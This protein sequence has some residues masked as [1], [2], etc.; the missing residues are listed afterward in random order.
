MTYWVLALVFFS[1]LVYYFQML[2]LRKKLKEKYE[3]GFMPDISIIKPL[4]GL[5]DNLYENLVSFCKQDYQQYEIVLSLEDYNDPA[6]KVAKTIKDK[7]PQKVKIVVDDS[8]KAL[9]PK[10]RK[11]IAGYKESQYSCFLISDSNVYVEPDYLKKTA[12]ALSDNVG[13][14]TNL[15]VGVREKS[16]G[17]MLENLQ[18]NTFIMLGTCFLD[19]FLK[20]PC[21]IGKSML[22]R[23]KDF[24]EIGGFDA[25]SD[26]LAEDY[27][28]GKLMYEKGKKVVLSNYII[29]NVNEY[30]SIKRFFNRHTRWAKI[31]WKIGGPKYF[32]EPITNPVFIA[33]F[34]PILSNFTNLSVM[35]FFV[36]LLIKISMDMQVY[37]IL[38]QKLNITLILA[39]IKD[40][41]IGIIWFVPFVT[42]KV[43]WR[44]NLYVISKNTKLI[45]I[46][47]KESVLKQGSF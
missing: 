19:V 46:K 3:P 32:I 39:P 37:R 23:K 13:V 33:L 40:L 1:F 18:I 27:M 6:Y 22:M 28:I 7:Y 31:R 44:G 9:N 38:N 25:I 43:N 16:L 47:N 41:L 15:I 29:Q 35:T 14:V 12:A 20:V 24:E 21:T 4:K 11:L 10:V 8:S 30:W 36:A 2:A 17:A 42:S 26:V 5:D 45:E 34:L